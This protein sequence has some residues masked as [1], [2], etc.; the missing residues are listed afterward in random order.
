LKKLLITIL[1]LNSILI[2]FISGCVPSKP[3]ENVEILPS[4][5]LINKLEA[6]RRRIR[7]FEGNGTFLVN[8]SMFNN[9]SASFHVVLQKPDSIYFTIMGPF[10]IELAQALV[11]NKNF[12]FYDDLHN[13][14]Y[15]G[16]VDQKILKDIFKINLSFNELMDSFIGSVNLTD[17]LYKNP[18]KYSVDYDEYVLTYIDSLTNRQTIYRVD[19]RQLGIT[20]YQIVDADGNKV[21]EGKYSDFAFIEGVAV[22]YKIVVTDFKNNQQVSINYKKMS[23][24]NPN[25]VVDFKIPDDATII[26]W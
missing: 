1:L 12:L 20:D 5:R 6:N 18:D 22:P 4:E 11:T 17:R 21:L 9:N 2:I 26:K 19:I 10:G 7:N 8:S 3:T 23:A 15:K 16:K 24:N 14:A 13:T 25:I